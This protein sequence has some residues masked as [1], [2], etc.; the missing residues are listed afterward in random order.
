MK[1]DP[2]ALDFAQIAYNDAKRRGEIPLP[3]AIEAYLKEADLVPR[4][5]LDRKFDAAA[6]KWIEVNMMGLVKER[7]EARMQLGRCNE[8]N[9]ELG[10]QLEALR[11]TVDEQAKDEGLWFVAKTEPEAYLQKALRRLHEI[12]EG[13]TSTERALEL[14]AGKD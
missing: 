8:A 12:I 6:E 14:L 5:E 10:K 7:D 11:K 13:K 3:F 4:S 9:K 2:K 1:H